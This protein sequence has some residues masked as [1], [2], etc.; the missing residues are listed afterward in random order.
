MPVYTGGVLSGKTLTQIVAG[1]SHTCALDSS[2]AAYCWGLN[3]SGQLGNNS[4]TQSLVPVAVT[5]SGVLSGKTLTQ[6]TAGNAH[7][8]ALDSSGAAYCWGANGNGQLG[9]NTTTRSLVPVAVTTSG[10]LSGETLTQITGGSAHTCAL[11]S[12]GA[13]Y[14]WGAN[15]NG[16][17]GNSSTTQSLV[18]VAVTT[19]GVLSGK[20]LTRSAPTKRDVHLCARR[21][22]RRV[23][24]GCRLL[25]PARERRRQL[26]PRCAGG[27]GY[28]RGAVGQGTH[29]DRDW[30]RFHV[31][32]GQHGRGVLLGSGRQRRAGQR[33]G[34]QQQ[35]AG[36][37]DDAGVLAGKTLTQVSLGHQFACA[38]SS[39]GLL[40][41]G[42]GLQR[43]A[44]EQQHDAKP[45]CPCPSRHR[46]P[47]GWPRSQAMPRRPS[48]GPRRSS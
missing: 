33:L 41:L 30:F 11:D 23:L 26:N 8:C 16:Q 18:P 6:I 3:S 14:C 22:R 25:R 35:R 39:A 19:S 27:R 9:N 10:V 47:R 44:G 46:D 13:A 28:L 20:T 2:G 31:R 43:P 42:V 40:L 4:V 37:G 17:L 45:R 24:L 7:T 32:G 36:G 48:R 21:R 1:F 38:L 29:P 34:R 5:T 15:G 12:T